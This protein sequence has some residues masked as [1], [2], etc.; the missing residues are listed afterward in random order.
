MIVVTKMQFSIQSTRHGGGGGGGG[1]RRR[2]GRD[3]SLTS[4]PM[5]IPYG[6]LVPEKRDYVDS[7]RSQVEAAKCF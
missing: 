1:A 7:L 4:K 6:I 3:N 2:R 5:F